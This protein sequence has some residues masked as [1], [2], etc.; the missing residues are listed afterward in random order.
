M[1]APH[2]AGFLA[3]TGT[4]AFLASVD[5][6]VVCEWF[7]PGR[8][9]RTPGRNLSVT[10]SVASLL[11]GQVIASGRL[12]GPDTALGDLVPGLADPAVARLRIDQL[13]R[14]GSGIR[15]R[16]GPL[17]WSD[18]ARVYHGT[19][20]RHAAMRVHVA[21]PVDAFFHY[22]DWHPLLLALALER[23]GSDSVAGLLARALWQP[24]GAGRAT[25]TLDHAGAGALPH[26]ES[27]LNTAPEDLL[28]CGQLVLQG[29]QWQGRQLVP[30]A[31]IERLDDP[32]GC[33]RTPEDFRYYARLPWGRPLATGRY[34][35]KDFWW[36]HFPRAG[37]HDVFAMGALG[38]HVYVSRDTRCV[39]VRQ[40]ERFPRGV[41]WAGLLRTLAEQ[42]A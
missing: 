26:L 7:A 41:W 39:I 13:L 27:G 36:H 17:P 18:D 5:G 24:L 35:Y 37:V 6:R 40:A 19:R 8:D 33:W 15:Y 16:E 23:A 10:K 32:A 2:L 31:W 4:T 14:M 3:A 22:N 1:A 29:G 38:A 25:L 21:D 20:L 30:A 34:G 42:L 28:R 9:A 12:G 11:T